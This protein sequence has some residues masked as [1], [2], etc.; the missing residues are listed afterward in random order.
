MTWRAEGL[1]AFAASETTFPATDASSRFDAS[2]SPEIDMDEARI[3]GNWVLASCI[4][5]PR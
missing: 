5:G 3:E 2:A 4:S 1:F